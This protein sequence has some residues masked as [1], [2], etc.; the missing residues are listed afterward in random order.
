MWGAHFR[1]GYGRHVWLPGGGAWMMFGLGGQIVYGDPARRLAA[2]VT[3]DT[4]SVTG[5]DQRLVD[6]LLPALAA[7]DLDRAADLDG[8]AAA[9]P[10]AGTPAASRD[11][12]AAAA[13]SDHELRPPAPPHDPS[14][15]RP[16]RGTYTAVS[17]ADAPAELDL[18]IDASGGELRSTIGSLQFST[19]APTAGDT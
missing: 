18:R 10:A 3:A 5:G 1:Q 2:V 9:G 15:A 12:D 7:A 6:L 8:A 13:A 11:A 14:A 17:A 4:T 16:A 19:A